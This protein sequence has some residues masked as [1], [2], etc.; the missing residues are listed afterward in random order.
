MNK[1][2][3]LELLRQS[4]G[5]SSAEFRKDQ[6]ETID[7]LVNHSRKLLV[8]QSTGWGKSSV[9]FISTRILRDRGKGVT[10]I[11]SPLL[12]LMRNQIE[13]A[14]RLGI[15]AESMNST[16]EEDW[17]RIKV[18][19][20]RDE[21]DALI[22][23][24]ERLANDYFRTEILQSI[25]DK[26]GLFVVDEAHCISDW[27][28]DFRPD[29]RRIVGILKFM[30]EGMPVLAT[31]ATANKRVCEDI[32]NQLGDIDI[33]R[34]PLVRSSLI[35]QNIILS[36]KEERLAWL[37]ENVPKLPCSGIIYALTKRD[38]E[39]VAHWLEKC[40]I[41]CERYYSGAINEEYTDS[42]AYREYV[43][44][45]FYENRVKVIVATSALGM[46]YDK[47]DIGFVIHF[48]APGSIIAYYQQV[49]RAG[50]AIDKA[51]GILFSGSEDGDIHAYFRQHA[52][53]SEQKVDTILNAL[54][55]SEGLS[56]RELEKIVNYKE[57]EITKILKY[58]QVENPA[59][60]TYI[61][62]KWKHLP[63][64]YEMDKDKILF[65]MNQREEEWQEVQTYIS[66][67]QCLMQFL[68]NVLDD[69]DC[70]TC[71]KCMNCDK[72]NQLSIAS[73]SKNIQEALLFLKQAEFDLKL[74]S[75]FPKNVFEKYTFKNY[76][77]NGPYKG[78]IGKVM[79]KWQDG[80]WGSIVAA[81]KHK[82][83]FREDLVDAFVKMIRNWNPSPMPTWVT[84]VPSL[85]HKELVPLFAKRVAEKLNIPFVDSVQKIIDTEP[86]KN[87]ENIYHQCKNL[88]G[89]FRVD[90]IY[91]NEPV[92]LI[93]DTVDSAWTL[94][95]VTALLREKGSG[96]VFPAVLTSTSSK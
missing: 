72:K 73:T 45:K 28:H 94:T 79:S 12:A 84:C 91:K 47:P 85:N 3:A 29:Y 68:Q 54:K 16:N 86:Q 5:N 78:E 62:K 40:D 64:V 83:F 69:D 34:G 36:R 33:V 71:G 50:R 37:K 74:K 1:R 53:P 17:K 51:Y 87:Q 30:P 58:L 77:Q 23:S 31:T 57:S 55:K 59:P 9:Y 60:I 25:A 67:N 8:V 75:Q 39:M 26:V 92:L 81:D 14:K 10:I 61:D 27:G 93:D 88:D 65:L 19:V 76:L 90:T 49:G 42:S 48:Q 38:V 95:I 52:F 21:I 6:W 32:K 96:P 44:K 82:G 24:P 41:S 2:K 20:L 35:L 13:A 66:Y 80:A 4:I 43:E 15:K 7:Q 70:S 22:I 11:I 89:A 56:V 46:G 18:R 63:V